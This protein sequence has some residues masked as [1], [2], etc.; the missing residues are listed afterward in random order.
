MAYQLI[1]MS[2]LMS[3]YEGRTEEGGDKMTLT[4]SRTKQTKEGTN[5]EGYTAIEKLAAKRG[6]DI[7]CG[8]ATSWIGSL[9]AAL[10]YCGH[11]RDKAAKM[12]AY[13]YCYNGVIF[14]PTTVFPTLR[15][16]RKNVEES[17]RR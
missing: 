6:F 2:G 4:S 3:P 15:L 5:M 11:D 17:T 9:N 7:T 8:P 14:E 10:A 13:S 1:K 12:H 16:L